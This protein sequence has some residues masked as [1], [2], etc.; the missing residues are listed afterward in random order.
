LDS[1]HPEVLDW[2]DEL[3]RK[4]TGWGYA[5]LKLDF[6]YQGALIG[7]RHQNTSREAAYRNAM[8]VIRKAPATLHSRL[9][10]GDAITGLCDGIRIG[11]DVTPFEKR[12]PNP[13]LN[14]PNETSTAN[15]IRTCVHRLWLRPW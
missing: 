7:N 15:A 11:P 1:S 14:N 6:L 12:V 3:I 13:W 9:W 10:L 4:V 8:Q 5:Y 2:L